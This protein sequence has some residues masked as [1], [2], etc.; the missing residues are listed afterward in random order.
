M[1]VRA[2]VHGMRASFDTWSDDQ[3]LEGTKSTPKYHWQALDFCLAHIAP[4]GKTKKSYRR[5]MMFESRIGIMNDW[6]DFCVPRETASA[7]S[8]DN[9]VK[10]P[11]SA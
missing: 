8:D 11:K 7:T 6:A 3:F 4:G 1:K 10:F 9:V 5:G 2:T